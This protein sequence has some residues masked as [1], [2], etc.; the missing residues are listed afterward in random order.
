MPWVM[1]SG[2]EEGD[3]SAIYAYLRSIDPISN[4]ME[5][6]VPDKKE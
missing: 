1:L 2:L 6:F 5:K 4:K 3:L